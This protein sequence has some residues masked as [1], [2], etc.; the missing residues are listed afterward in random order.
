MTVAEELSE[1]VCRFLLSN[2][3]VG[4]VAFVDD[5]DYPV[6]LPVNYRVDGD[7]IIFQTA[8]GAKLDLVPLRKVAFQVDHLAPSVRAGWS[9]LVKG[10]GH[11][12]TSAIG[13]TYEHLREAPLEHWDPGVK[14][15]WIG[16]AIHSISG[17]QIA[18][19]RTASPTEAPGDY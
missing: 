3:E 7:L 15:Y 17:R 12:L 16:I 4:R 11:E 19:P 14:D 8:P 18:N 13:S 1:E 9:V 5:D 2:E 6:V 10:V